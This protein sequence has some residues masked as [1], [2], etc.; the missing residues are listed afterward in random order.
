MTELFLGLSPT[1]WTAI[2]T[3]VLA[4]IAV[5][6]VCIYLNQLATNKEIERAYVTMSHYPPGLIINPDIHTFNGPPSQNVR[7]LVRIR[8]RGNTPALVTFTLVQFHF[9]PLP[10]IPPYDETKGQIMD[11]SFAKDGKFNVVAFWTIPTDTLKRMSVG[12]EPLFIFG[13]ADYIDRFKD[14]HRVGWARRYD[15]FIE[16]PD[17]YATGK[18]PKNRNNL[19]FVTTP[20]YN[21]DRKRKKGEGHDWENTAYEHPP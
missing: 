10:A 13:Y 12:G 4:V 8:N 14:R 2:L 21:Y 16:V 19:P 15:R 6:Q 17:L 7:V 1:A 3:L 5:V 20:G 18:L 11:A 9:G